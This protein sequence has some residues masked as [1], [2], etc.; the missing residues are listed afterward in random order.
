M[1]L[2]SSC[3]QNDWQKGSNIEYACHQSINIQIVYTQTG[4]I[5]GNILGKSYLNFLN[6]SNS[7]PPMIEPGNPVKIK[8][9]PI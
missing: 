3:E 9:K 7:T 2:N 6:L 8:T 4:L 1:G 5:M